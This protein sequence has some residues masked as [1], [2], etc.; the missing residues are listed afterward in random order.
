MGGDTINRGLGPRQLEEVRE[1]DPEGRIV[2]HH[3]TVDTL[4]KMLRAGA[5][6]PGDA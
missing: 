1:L 3:R 5:I 6:T 4:D 2:V